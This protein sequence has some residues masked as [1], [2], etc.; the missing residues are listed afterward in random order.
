MTLRPNEI[1]FVGTTPFTIRHQGLSRLPISPNSQYFQLS[2]RL[3]RV[4][5]VRPILALFL[6]VVAGCFSAPAGVLYSFSEPASPPDSAVNFDFTVPSLI[7]SPTV[8]PATDINSPVIDVYGLDLSIISVTIDPGLS[9]NAL[10]IGSRGVGFVA[11]RAGLGTQVVMSE[12]ICFDSNSSCYSTLSPVGAEA[13][14]HFGVYTGADATL[15]I[16]STDAPQTLTPEPRFETGGGLLVLLTGVGMARRTG[17]RITAKA[18][19]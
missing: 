16:S 1:H 11:I 13:F 2:D 19:S 9:N 3:G 18:T 10:Y 15:T 8:I 5:Y 4:R 17:R 7:T 12:G 6:L 14:D